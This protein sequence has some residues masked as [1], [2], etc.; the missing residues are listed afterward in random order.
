MELSAL[1]SNNRQYFSPSSSLSSSEVTNTS[2]QSA[3]TEGHHHCD[4]AHEEMDTE[5]QTCHS[6]PCF[7]A[8]SHALD[9][10]NEGNEGGD[11]DGDE[12]E[13][14]E[15]DDDDEDQEENQEQR[16][17]H[18]DPVTES[19]T[20]PS[21][22]I[23]FLNRQISP[24]TPTTSSSA[25]TRCS[26]PR[27]L[28]RRSENRSRSNTRSTSTITNTNGN[29][30]L[31]THDD[32]NSN[33]NNDDDDDDDHHHERG[34]K[35]SI[36]SEDNE[37]NLLGSAALGVTPP[38]FAAAT[39]AA[40]TT[41]PA[42]TNAT[43]ETMT[44]TTTA[45]AI[46]L[47][48]TSDGT[49]S[50]DKNVFVS[51]HRTLKAP[52][53]RPHTSPLTSTSSTTL[54]SSS[55][56]SSSSSLPDAATTTDSD[57]STPTGLL[58]DQSRTSTTGTHSTSLPL[59]DSSIAEEV[60]N[61][62]TS[63]LHSS[64]HQSQQPQSS[65]T[66]H[67]QPPFRKR[68]FPLA[69][70]RHVSESHLSTILSSTNSSTD[71]PYSHPVS[72]TPSHDL[73]RV[74][75]GGISSAATSKSG[76][77]SEESGNTS[78]R[79]VPAD[80]DAPPVPPVPP[81]PPA[82]QVLVP[83]GCTQPPPTI[84]TTSPTA[85]GGG[86]YC[87]LNSVTDPQLHPQ[88]QQQQQHHHQP[89]SSLPTS[90][91]I[92]QWNLPAQ[93]ARFQQNRM[94]EKEE[95][96]RARIAAEQQYAQRS[97]SPFDAN[98]IL[99][100][101]SIWTTTTTPMTAST[102]DG[103]TDRDRDEEGDRERYGD[104]EGNKEASRPQSRSRKLLSSSFASASSSTVRGKSPRPPPLPQ[105]QPRE[106]GNAV[107]PSNLYP[108]G[109]QTV[110]ETSSS[111]NRHPF[112]IQFPSFA[113]STKK[114]HSDSGEALRNMEPN[115]QQSPFEA[116]TFSAQ[117]STSFDDRRRLSS[118]NLLQGY[119]HELGT[120]RHG[121][122]STSTTRSDKSWR[123]DTSSRSFERDRDSNYGGGSGTSGRGHPATQGLSSLFSSLNSG[124][125]A[126]ATTKADNITMTSSSAGGS[127]G[128][129]YGG[130][131]PFKTNPFSRFARKKRAKTLF[132]L[133][134]RVNGN[135]P[136]APG[137]G[138]DGGGYGARSVPNSAFGSASISPESGTPIT[139][140]PPRNPCITSSNL[141]ND[142]N[143]YNNGNGGMFGNLG[144]SLG[145]N[146][147]CQ[148]QMSH[149]GSPRANN[150]N[151][152][153]HNGPPSPSL[154]AAEAGSHVADESPTRGFQGS[155]F[156]TSQSAHSM[157]VH[158]P[159]PT[160]HAS[161][162][163]TST[164]GSSPP[165][166]QQQQQQS[167]NL[168]D[169]TPL[170]PSVS[171]IDRKDSG[172][173]LGSSKSVRSLRVPGNAHHH[174][175]TFLPARDS[176]RSPAASV[177][178][179]ES[180]MSRIRSST[181]GSLPIP[182]FGHSGERHA[183]IASHSHPKSDRNSAESEGI[184]LASRNS[185]EEARQQRPQIHHSM[186]VDPPHQPTQRENRMF[187]SSPSPVPGTTGTGASLSPNHEARSH[188][189]NNSSTASRKSF[190]DFFHFSTRIRQN[191][192][193]Q[194]K[195][196]PD[197][198]VLLSNAN[199]Q[200]TSGN[201]HVLPNSTG[202]PGTPN[203]IASKANPMCIT[204]DS[205]APPRP[206]RG[207]DD[208][209]AEYLFTLETKVPR[210]C[211]ATILSQSNDEFYREALRRYMNGFSFYNDPLDMS[212]RKMLMEVELPKETQEIDRVL[213]SFAERYHECNP[214]IFEGDDQA[215]FI[216]FSLLI[217][218]TDV[219]N[220]NNKRKMQKHDYVRNTRDDSIAD[221]I[222]ECFYDNISYT[223]FIHVEDDTSLNAKTLAPSTSA[224]L[225][226]KLFRV[227]STD[228]LSKSS[229]DPVD[230]YALILEGRLSTLRPDLKDVIELE[231]VYSYTS[232][233]YNL[234]G[235]ALHRAFH[236]SSILQIVSARSRPDAFRAPESIENPEDSHPGLVAIRVAKVG[237][238]WRKDPR[239]KRAR[240]PWQEWGVVLTG[241]Q[242]YFFR[243]VPWVKTLI[244]QYENAQK[245][246]R[247]H[248][249]TFK[250]PLTDFKPDAI[251]STEEAVV[252]RDASYKR[253]KHAFLLVRHGG[254]E[255]VFL[256]TSEVEMNEWMATINYAATFRTMGVNM[257]GMIGG[258]Y[259]CPFETDRDRM[260][261]DEENK[262]KE[263]GLP[264]ERSVERGIDL[265]RAA[266]LGETNSNA[267]SAILPTDKVLRRTRR[268]DP[269]LVEEV[270]V[271]RRELLSSRIR[272]A[273]QKLEEAQK[274]L[275]SLLRNA[276]HLQILTP[277]HPR[278]RDMVVLAAGRIAAK[279]KWARMD[280]WRTRCYRDILT[281]DLVDDERQSRS[282]ER[283]K[284]LEIVEKEEEEGEEATDKSP[285]HSRP[286]TGNCHNPSKERKRPGS[287]RSVSSLPVKPLRHV[288][289]TKL[290][291]S[292][293]SDP[294]AIAL[295]RATSDG[296]RPSKTAGDKVNMSQPPLFCSSKDETD[297]ASA[298]R[299][300]ADARQSSATEASS[301]GS[302]TGS[303]PSHMPAQQHTI[304]I[305]PRT[306]IGRSKRTHRS[307][308]KTL[309]EAHHSIGLSSL[310]SRKSSAGG[311]GHSHTKDETDGNEKDEPALSRR[312]GSFTVHGKK[313]SVVTFGAQW[314]DLSPEERL[315][316]RKPSSSQAHSQIPVGPLSLTS[317]A[318]DAPFA[319]AFESSDPSDHSDTS[320]APSTHSYD[321]DTVI[322]DLPTRGDS[323]TYMNMHRKN[324]SSGMS[325]SELVNLR[326]RL[327]S[328]RIE[329]LNLPPSLVA[330]LPS[331]PAT[332]VSSP[333]EAVR[334]TSPLVSSSDRP[335]SFALV[336]P[337]TIQRKSTIRL[338]RNKEDGDT[339][340][341]GAEFRPSTAEGTSTNK[342]L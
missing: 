160:G 342:D 278:A 16:D 326:G 312:H 315:K 47:P 3:S 224:Q 110:R 289:S 339:A 64:Q 150:G 114:G 200:T 98:A 314:Q 204:K 267:S 28:R 302:L 275:D 128:G 58:P 287:K 162:A 338:V 89:P 330:G 20:H 88:Q 120:V 176:G 159:S 78:S 199:D 182:W 74:L 157:R 123:G 15:E 26:D 226:K 132:P 87:S 196:A 288:R 139:G 188:V 109:S 100:S 297:P 296:Y 178:K 327:Q 251:M 103:F 340:L 211:I 201:G 86:H 190:G 174:N 239:K 152:D 285:S 263:Q 257:R 274:S 180:R 60:P 46:P 333:P 2:M 250:P 50:C 97:P 325:D 93:W 11:E 27:Q 63:Q 121:R 269:C 329:E 164:G 202:Q 153:D 270:S 334:M 311:G 18:Y 249:V 117:R 1:I 52:L 229:K 261:R 240:S 8:C 299:V 14:E 44:M 179:G 4:R 54:S 321:K 317:A 67:Q 101:D 294:P 49:D 227:G 96:E 308:Q 260:Q 85:D 254:F 140:S 195:F 108:S 66:P 22:N 206:V 122:L 331:R 41:T 307:L 129:G 255:E 277:I 225:R 234:D 220:K 259:Q 158:T 236:K 32:D 316:M 194:N 298:T 39:A 273:E 111:T 6:S 125:N 154:S 61:S 21:A 59:T 72:H 133:P 35:T 45:A 191:S 233:N 320:R 95:K 163:Q 271:A 221:E 208:T 116:L 262:D 68:R 335:S 57:S 134:T 172:R 118:T 37:H 313:A 24:C 276:R 137:F 328:S 203:T 142:N 34:D 303:Y 309:R 318:A 207:E 292:Y 336:D 165:S 324:S 148:V 69:R 145:R 222:L 77:K 71:N 319:S 7:R 53:H 213:Q 170:H 209:P 76:R 173:S 83:N 161:A 217:L 105:Q 92:S 149:N 197:G 272:E 245:M 38:S 228:G 193:P 210:A 155:I 284:P 17:G 198:H 218:H 187:S 48:L 25:L 295:R 81:L 33:S 127:G 168:A 215:Y 138:S 43:S 29:Q 141:N 65:Q 124:Q 301:S 75:S 290:S 185:D 73:D 9:E 238:L 79:P 279:I 113:R 266:A 310:P 130:S 12:D 171:A 13:E 56:S 143:N 253:H 231:D 264:P 36:D 252:L 70:F 205:P 112:S 246:G 91:P 119:G 322:T 291:A 223:P 84:I 62:P 243:D 323:L 82:M 242:L 19:A 219:F 23:P 248:G 151:A 156:G 305:Q 55:S 332:G 230:P 244:A 177:K 192:E 280:I 51:G 136:P 99:S 232:P 235:T 186:T 146:R 283:A 94:R 241:S 169:G 337:D 175:S 102:G 306:N 258:Q 10:S 126:N 166:Q 5:M 144:L 184:R 115:D 300:L 265:E 183:H 30:Q 40:A 167:H 104:R 31:G 237:I 189:Y 268:V 282:F 106:A 286:S 341:D 256:A 135:G 107:I 147:G 214:G 304:E 181:V 131:S 281:V 212:L 42:T 90:A 247:K 293:D 80:A 216:A